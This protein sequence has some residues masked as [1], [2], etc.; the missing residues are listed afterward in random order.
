MGKYYFIELWD[1]MYDTEYREYALSR[2][3]SLGYSQYVSFVKN[4]KLS[5]HPGYERRKVFSSFPPKK[6][7]ISEYIEFPIICEKID[8]DFFEDVLSG[9]RILNYKTTK[10]DVKSPIIVAKP[11]YRIAPS[12]AAKMLKSLNMDEKQRYIKG[13]YQIEKAYQKAYEKMQQNII[14]QNASDLAGE[15]YIKQL[16]N[17]RKH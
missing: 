5:V 14:K 10:Y 6:V 2:E 3:Y 8:E 13:M 4:V 11:V 1:T 7:T 16:K 12:E 17:K 9:T 15:E